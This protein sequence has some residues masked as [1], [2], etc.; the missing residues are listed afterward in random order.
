M[1]TF[2][3]SK[4]GHLFYRGAVRTTPEEFKTQHSL[5]GHFGFVFEKKSICRE[6]TSDEYC[7]IIVFDKPRFQTFFLST[8]RRKAGVFKFFQSEE[9]L[10]KAAFSLR[11]GVEGKPNRRNKVASSNFSSVV[12]ALPPT[13]SL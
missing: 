6:N 12:L 2:F 8:R 4:E 13:F 1:L 9:R 3:F 10:R 11:I 7:D 5:N